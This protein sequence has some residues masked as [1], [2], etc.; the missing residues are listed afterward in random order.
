MSERYNFQ[1][2]EKKWQ[3]FWEE[4]DVFH[5]EEDMSKEKYYVLEMFPYPSGKLHMGHV[6]NY[7]IGDVTA[8]Y[9]RMKGL[10]VLHPMGW[11]SFGL[12]AE[13][14]AIK[15]GILPDKWTR[16]NIVEMK[17]QF[18]SL[19]L[20]YDWEREIATCHKDY[21]KWMQW[22]FI[23]FFNKGLAY[24]K[25]NPVNWC[26]SCQTVL[27]NEQVVNGVCERCKTP[28]G[29][30]NL[31]QWYLRITDYAERLLDDLEKLEG[32]PEKVK[33]M[34]KNWI[35][36]SIGAEVEFEIEGFNKKLEIFTTRP[37][38][39][40]G[41]TCMIL[42]PEHPYVKELISDDCK[43]EVD[44]FMEKLQYL[45]DIDRNSTTL[46]K[47]GCFLG[48]YAV[49]PLTGDKLPIYIANYVLMDYGTGAIMVVPAHDQRDFDFCKKYDI[50][51]VPVIDPEDPA[52][53]VNDL[54]E[55]FAAEGKLI[56]S[57][58]FDGLDNKDAIIKI[59]DHIEKLGIG[60]KSVNYRLRDW[61][62]SRQRYWGSP[63]PMIYCEDCGWVPEKEENLPV[64]LPEDVEF[65][66]KGESPLATSKN[67]QNTVCPKCGKA[68]K[69]ELDTMDTF[70]DSSWYFLRYADAKNENA[71]FD[72]KKAD[73]WMAVDQYIGGVEH[74]ILHL[75]YSRFFTKVLY[76]MDMVNVE[77]PFL[78]L[79]TQGMV[80]KDGSKMSKS[81][82]N[83]VSPQEIIKKYG[84]D[85]AR[86]FILFAAPPD[87][88][89]DWSDSGVEGSYRFLNRV[90]RIVTDIIESGSM[91][92]SY[93]V[94]SDAGKALYYQLNKSVKKVTDDLG[95]DRMSFNTAISSIMELVN[96]MYRYKDTSDADYALLAAAAEKLVLL[97]SPFA[98]HI[99]EEMWSL[100][101]KTNS[102]YFERWP[103]FD[104]EALV[105]DTV[106][107][108]VQI[109]G[110]VRMKADVENGLS[111]EELEA[112]MLADE[113]VKALIS[114]KE[115]VKVIAVPGK[116]I[117]IVVK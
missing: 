76:D 25:K 1:K 89:L 14:A 54:K 115:V 34:Q 26:P 107:I 110:K 37:D 60:K 42:A 73:Y 99:S 75:L 61:L 112:F 114:G 58:E 62:I 77:E 101:G 108:V 3:T 103:E 56:N 17:E 2:I 32:W 53:D 91:G 6:R 79:L 83:I 29:K 80:L 93:T 104:A 90:W 85:T 87:R 13:N 84:S 72:K 117:N 74:A 102:V 67:F 23:K 21:Y 28:V 30:K 95:E 94:S 100:M 92:K 9:M 4:N 31:S 98:P 59:V 71:P 47:E 78:K 63:I 82:G 18:N 66:G 35:G 88:D 20:S 97:I 10:N 81:V 11:D 116:L 109:N 40:F 106:E 96:E 48:R 43:V 24:K 39:I 38:T 19:G 113:K 36:K 44:A 15:N 55:A 51:I 8:R 46:E 68:A 65:T 45:S 33:L 50:N 69:R 22:L 70:V 64:L 12:P 5:T 111:R 86:M 27:A 52:I 16:E 41:T 7:S 57:G 49:N 105:L